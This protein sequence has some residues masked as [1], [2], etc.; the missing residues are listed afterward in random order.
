[1]VRIEGIRIPFTEPESALKQLVCQKLRIP[2]SGIRSFCI[3]KKAVDARKRQTIYFVYSV[4][5]EPGHAVNLKKIP[6]LPRGWILREIAPFSFSIRTA[7]WKDVEHRPIIAGTGPCGLFCGLV[8]AK[9]GLRPLLLERGKC[10]DDRIRD[11][12][13]FT[14]TG[15]LDPESNIQF[16]EGGAGTFSDGKL[17]TLIND[18]LTQF[19]FDQLIEAG[20][21]PEI[22]HDAKPHI[23]T[24]KLRE[25]LKNLRKKIIHFGGEIRFESKLT[26]CIVRNQKIEAIRINDL[27]TCPV[28]SLI[29]AIGHSARDTVRML[30]DKGLH[31]TPKAFSMGIRIEHLKEWIQKAQY[32]P[33]W[34]HPLLPS[35]KYKLS[36]HL[37]GGRGV[38]TFCMCPGGTVVPAASEPG[39]V[40]TNGMSHYAQDGIN[41][42]SAVLVNV[43]PE[44]YGGGALDGFVFQ[45]TWEQSAYQAGGGTFAAPAQTLGDFLNG[46]VSTEF[47]EVQ[48]TYRPGT[49]FADLNTCLPDFVSD[50]LKKAIPRLNRKMRGFLHPDAVLTGIETRSSSPVRMNRDNDF[51]CS[52]QGVFPAGEGAG[53]AGGI[54]SSAADGIRTAEKVLARLE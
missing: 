45:R 49:V 27:E 19:I 42:N 28:Q 23:G 11:V 54:V 30:F 51:Q 4:D 34:N 3:S 47:R 38:Y 37:P 8:L 14:E 9:A 24:D 17:Y 15:V 2:E 40:V 52:I 35:A 16:G 22:A 50:A 39:G 43:Y 48:P 1:M 26:G 44:D 25:V 18:P 33:L 46:R 6:L 41:S 12:N 7:G 53:Y 29:L 31:M 20:A 5:L 13:R 36:E 21:P 10:V 32:G